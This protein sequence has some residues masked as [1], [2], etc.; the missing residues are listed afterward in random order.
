MSNKN[1]KPDEVLSSHSIICWSRCQNSIVPII[2]GQCGE[3]RVTTVG[4]VIRKGFTG[5]CRK[6]SN[7]EWRLADDE[8]V[9]NGIILWSRRADPQVPVICGRCRR[10]RVV[11][12]TFA[13]QE[14]FTG[15]CYSCASGERL[16]DETLENGS[17]IFWSKRKNGKVP[18]L[19]GMCQ[20]ERW[21]DLPRTTRQDFTGLCFDCVHQAHVRE[22]AT[23]WRG[24]RF[25]KN[26]YIYV[27]VY[28]DHP[29]FESM[30]DKAGYILEHRLVMA[31]HLGRPLQSHEIVHHKNGNKRD[32][33][34]QNLQLLIGKSNHHK[35]HL[36]ID[37]HPGYEPPSTIYLILEWFKHKLMGKDG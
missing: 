24:G 17:I 37:P 33:T 9:T 11:R 6:C 20:K 34:I 28:P 22:N 16:E 19:C 5:I 7:R 8:S 18:T 27:R 13:M 30:A 23:N 32:N 36:E 4:N 25:K 29:F 21:I 10:E 2:C 15:L 3:E 31:R 26:G 12:I 35:A 1:Q 14:R